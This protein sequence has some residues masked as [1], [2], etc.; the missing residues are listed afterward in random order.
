M[1]P[2][3]RTPLRRVSQ[4]SLF[5]VSSADPDPESGTAFL[6]AAISE[7][8][9]E[10]EQLQNTVEGLRKLSESLT[11]FNESFA[12]YLY[13]MRMNALTID[14][15]QAPTENSFILSKQRMEREAIAAMEAAQA[16]ARAATAQ[17]A[18]ER[19]QR[20]AELSKTVEQP[21][22]DT[23][24]TAGHTTASASK[25]ILKKKPTGKPKL[26][27]KQKKE[28]SR[29]IEKVV[30][31]LPL[32]FR[33][34]DPHLRRHMELVIDGFFDAPNHT[35][36]LTDLIKPPDLSQ[37]RVNKCLIALVNRKIVSKNSSTGTV[38]YYWQGV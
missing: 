16:K 22:G 13:V 9:D 11:T 20:E 12:S 25:S 37:A 18:R 33:G 4:S 32:E 26:S 24:Y 38:L 30:L 15:V 23:T 29:E 34:S 28:R 8:A 17:A 6:D 7:L 35:V 2:P 10:S 1:P 3:P 36:K 14:F 21:E 31:C 27:A 5:A 19:E